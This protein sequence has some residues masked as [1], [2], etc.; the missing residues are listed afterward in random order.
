MLH[1]ASVFGEWLVNKESWKFK[2]N[3]KKGGKLFTIRDGLKFDDM[4]HMVNEDFGIDKLIHEVELSYALLEPMMKNMPKDTPPVFVNNDRQLDSFCD[5]CRSMPVRLCISVK[6]LNKEHQDQ[7]L[8]FREISVVSGEGDKKM[9]GNSSNNVGRQNSNDEIEV[10]FSN[11]H[12]GNVI[13]KGQWFKS[14]SDLSWKIRMLAIERKFRFFVYKSDTKL[15]V[16]K[17][18]DKNCKWKIRA[19]KKK[20]CEYFWVTKYIDNHT[21]LSRNIGPPKASS[22]V[23]SK[24]ILEMPV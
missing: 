3:K 16:V 4:I 17:C 8:N 12:D 11:V 23:M 1:I 18:V 20:T 13:Q 10:E 2:V 19:T 7:G 14:K 5:I 21:C 6:N 24:L 9:K 22:K 15:L